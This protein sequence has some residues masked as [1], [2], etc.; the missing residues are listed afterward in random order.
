ML[1]NEIVYFFQ[2]PF[3]TA[4]SIYHPKNCIFVIFI[5]RKNLL[6]LYHP[7][8]CKSYINRSA[9]TNLI[10]TSITNL[11]FHWEFQ[12]YPEKA[13]NLH[14]KQ[15]HKIGEPD[16]TS[17][18]KSYRIYQKKFFQCLLLKE[19]VIWQGLL[20]VLAFLLVFEIVF[21]II[22]VCHLYL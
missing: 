9:L 2:R 5:Y 15:I 17:S 19:R 22:F 6:K 20:F 1:K 16:K 21:C 18:F 8:Q 14:I 7:H 4:V 12:H 10:L 11:I 13:G 3:Q